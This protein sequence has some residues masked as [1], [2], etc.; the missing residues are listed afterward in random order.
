MVT[1]PVSGGE[2]SVDY[3]ADA[4][5]EA[6]LE[7]VVVSEG[8]AEDTVLAEGEWVLAL[9]VEGIALPGD[10]FVVTDTGLDGEPWSRVIYVV[11]TPGPHTWETERVVRCSSREPDVVA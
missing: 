2:W 8:P 10:R 11:G 6:R 4:I 9:P 3:P 5:Y 1:E 7:P